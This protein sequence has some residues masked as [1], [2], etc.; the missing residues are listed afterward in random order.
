M[1][2]DEQSEQENN[3]VCARFINTVDWRNNPAQRHETF[4]TYAD[5]V[6]WAGEA[7]ILSDVA[8][9]KLVKHASRN[10]HAA[11]AALHDA[12]LLRESLYAIFSAT[13]LGREPPKADLNRLNAAIQES[14]K[15]VSLVQSNA[16]GFRWEWQG[17]EDYFDRML[18]PI[19]R[20]AAELLTSDNLERLRECEA[21]GCG[22]IFLDTTRNRSR[23]W[24][25]MES[26]GNRAKAQRFYQRHKADSTLAR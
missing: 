19:V 5:L 10:R 21:E 3:P 1:T 11:E 2:A 20:S 22:W 26:C 8:A 9:H 13:S 7:G 16:G 15:H 4:N 12:L 6:K 17:K 23:R 25:S 14:G 24:C 18:W